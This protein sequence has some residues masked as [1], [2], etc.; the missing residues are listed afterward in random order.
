MPGNSA[1]RVVMAEVVFR[2]PWIG[3]SRRLNRASDHWGGP[4]HDE[5]FTAVP[6]NRPDRRGRLGRG[7][8][9]RSGRRRG[10]SPREG[11]CPSLEGTRSRR[12]SSGVSGGQPLVELVRRLAWRQREGHPCGGGEADR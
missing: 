3:Y 10:A 12:G 5:S 4:A 7:G 1:G 11:W 8:S 2:P 6:P 9:R